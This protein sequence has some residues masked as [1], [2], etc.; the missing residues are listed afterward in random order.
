M[1]KY[2]IYTAQGY[3]EDPDG[4]EV[5]NYQ[6]LGWIQAND[7]KEAVEKFLNDNSWVSEKGYD[8][9]GF[10]A[11]QLSDNERVLVY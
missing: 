10:V 6:I 9:H 5:D 2:V 3:C 11:Q 8:K 7:K 1:N 4:N